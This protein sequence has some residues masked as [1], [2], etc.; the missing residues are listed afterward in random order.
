M[1]YSDDQTFNL[2]AC[3]AEELWITYNR[4][5]L[6]PYSKGQEFMKKYKLYNTKRM[7]MSGEQ[8]MAE[9]LSDSE[10][11]FEWVLGLISDWNLV[12]HNKHEKA[13]QVLPLPSS[14]EG[15]WM[16]IP[17]LYMTFIV[18]TIKNDP[19]GSDFL[20]KGIQSSLVTS[21]QSSTD[22]TQEETLTGST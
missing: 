10:A 8:T 19:T 14:E 9:F 22:E 2:K 17:G 12:Y 13:G 1:S 5:G 4:P 3:G 20:V 15:I 18:Q 6:M 11:E 16:E 21:M 7:D